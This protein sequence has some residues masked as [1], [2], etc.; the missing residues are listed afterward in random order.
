M[1]ITINITDQFQSQ[2]LS[3]NL[4]VLRRN[5]AK[6]SLH[7]KHFTSLDKPQ[8]KENI[9]IFLTNQI[10]FNTQTPYFRTFQALG[11]DGF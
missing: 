5:F 11:K 9:F 1:L 2:F 4:N 3:R 7:Y 8:L 6:Y 10:Q